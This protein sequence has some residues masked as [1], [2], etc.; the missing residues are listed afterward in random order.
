LEEIFGLFT[1]LNSSL[2]RSDKGLGVGLS[3]VRMLVEMHGGEVCAHSD[4]PGK[5]SR[6]EIKLPTSEAP[7]DDVHEQDGHASVRPVSILIVEDIVDT[8]NILRRLLSLDGHDVRE[9]GDGHMGLAALLSNPPDV[10][11][12]D[13]GLPGLTGYEVARIARKNPALDRVRLV[14]LTG[15]GRPEDHDAVLAAGFDEHLVKPV[16]PADL[17]KVLTPRK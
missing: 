14:A 10:A 11:L 3:L 15:Y 13:V 16:N 9:A 5:G 2:D 17:A 4:G 8:R 1:Q 12:V 7:A 6:F